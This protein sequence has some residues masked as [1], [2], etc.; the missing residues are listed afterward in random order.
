LYQNQRSSNAEGT[1]QQQLLNQI[2]SIFLAHFISYYSSFIPGFLVPTLHEM[3]A[4]SPLSCA[5]PIGVYTIH[6]FNICHLVYFVSFWLS[7]SLY[8]P[9]PIPFPMTKKKKR[10]RI[11]YRRIEY[12]LWILIFH[13]F[14]PNFYTFKS[15]KISMGIGA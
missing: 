12:I 1:L 7:A 5:P 8:T 10:I 13:H 14:L 2:F 6:I 11:S 9:L 3:F 15:K 4:L